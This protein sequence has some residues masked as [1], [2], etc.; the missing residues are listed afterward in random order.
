MTTMVTLLCALWLG[1]EILRQA[2]AWTV[3]RRQGALLRSQARAA[4]RSCGEWRYDEVDVL[5]AIRGGDPGLGATLTAVLAELGARGARLHW[6]L[7]SDDAAALAAARQALEA[8]PEWASQV[9]L[10]SHPPCPERHNPKL[11]K[12]ARALPECGRD[13]VL[14]LDDDAELPATSLDA[15]LQALAPDRVSAGPVVATALPVYRGVAWP[16]IRPGRASAG[17]AAALLARFVNDQAALTYLATQ[18][19]SAA[20][21]LNGMCWLIARADLL[22][23]GGFRSQ[24]GQLTDDLAMARA[25]RCAAGRIEQRHEPVWL[26]TTL[27]DLRSYLRQMHRWQLFALLLLRSS[28]AAERRRLLIMLGLPQLLPVLGLLGLLVAPTN[29]AALCAAAAFSLQVVGRWGLQQACSGQ[30]PRAQPLLSLLATLL[31]PLHAAHAAL[32]RRIVWR[33]HR[34]RVLASD[35]F[36]E[37]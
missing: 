18:N 6:L 27:A 16:Q 9:V 5:Q 12:L 8:L 13:F 22:A 21:S 7:D 26:S 30:A 23:L 17:L 1:T 32:D 11:Y 34:Y 28:S 36:E 2:K 29:A 10:S 4:L 15:L 33:Q 24:L 14:V 25:I 37:I 35:R 3:L 19:S 31:L 20:L